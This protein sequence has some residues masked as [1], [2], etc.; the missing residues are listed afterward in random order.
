MPISSIQ[1]LVTINDTLYAR[2]DADNPAGFLSRDAGNTWIAVQPIPAVILSDM[3]GSPDLPLTLCNP[4]DVLI[5][6]R[7]SG[8]P[9]VEGSQDGGSTWRVVWQIPPERE[10]YL[11]RAVNSGL[12]S[13]GKDPT[14]IPQ[15]MAFVTQPG[16]STLVVAMG[17]EGVVIHSSSGG[18][19]RAA[20]GPFILP[21]PLAATSLDVAFTNVSI[22]SIF[23]SY[24]GWFDL[25]GI[26]PMGLD[27]C[28]PAR[29]SNGN[30]QAQMGI[31]PGM[32]R[33]RLDSSSR[34]TSRID[35]INP[36]TAHKYY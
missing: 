10:S 31:S 2:M 8:Q 4:G 6:F 18:W 15:D 26:E 14:M 27:I 16:G 5:C 23:W 13:C 28:S 35:W 7:I 25:S 33:S 11:Q 30:S 24:R 21:T 20:V 9:W 19:Q 17:N 12:M 22:E 29:L 36:G 1:R 32:V 3:A 34:G